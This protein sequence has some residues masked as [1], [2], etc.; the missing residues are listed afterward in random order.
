[1]KITQVTSSRAQIQVSDY[2]AY[3]SLDPTLKVKEDP[4]FMLQLGLS[5]NVDNDT[6]DYPLS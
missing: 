6:S 5:L 3:S 2:R 1:M 4:N